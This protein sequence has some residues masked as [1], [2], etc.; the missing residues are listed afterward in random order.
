MA[1]FTLEG[2]INGRTGVQI[3]W[4][5]GALS[6]DEQ[7]V[8]LAQKWLA[9]NDGHLIV[10][11]GGVSASQDHQSNPYTSCELI[12]MLLQHP[13]IVDGE[14]PTIPPGPEGETF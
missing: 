11:S 10:A 5:D 4:K 13:E 6:G 1:T 14:L 2:N 7:L 12:S 8:D 9:A 3:T